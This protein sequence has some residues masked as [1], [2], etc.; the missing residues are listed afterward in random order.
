SAGDLR[1]LLAPTAHLVSLATGQSFTA[2]P[3]GWANHPLRF[4][5]APAYAGVNSL[6]VSFVA[7]VLAFGRSWRA[8]AACAAAP[9]PATPCAHPLRIT[10][11]IALH[12]HHVSFLGGFLDEERL[13]RLVGVAI[14]LAVLLVLFALARRVTLAGGGRFGLALACYFGMTLVIPFLR[15][16]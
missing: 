12:A 15:G 16:A 3:E 2:T 1:I 5:I 10:I 11:A 9:R 6:V 14:Y 4:L 8:L 13:H 7:L